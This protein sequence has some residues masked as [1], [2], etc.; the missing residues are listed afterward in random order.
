MWRF[1]DPGVESCC[2]ANRREFSRSLKCRPMSIFVMVVAIDSSCFRSLMM[3]KKKSAPSVVRR[4][5]ADSSAPVL[6]SFLKGVAFT[7]PITAVPNTRSDRRKNRVVDPPPIQ[8]TRTRQKKTAS[9]QPARATRSRQMEIVEED[10]PLEASIPV[11]CLQG[12]P[13]AGGR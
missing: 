9:R 1:A 7:K 13:I 12:C 11:P 6:A 2:G 8:A 10:R 5:F 3:N 4:N